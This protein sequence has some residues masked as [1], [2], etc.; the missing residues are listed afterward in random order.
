M[1]EKTY[2]DLLYEASR[3]RDKLMEF[4]QVLLKPKLTAPAIT[5]SWGNVKSLLTQVIT[6]GYGQLPAGWA[7]KFY[8]ERN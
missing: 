8:L 4:Y 2:L 7:V 5:G 6:S 1:E 3:K